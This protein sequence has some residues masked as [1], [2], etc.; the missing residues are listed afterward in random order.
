[1]EKDFVNVQLSPFGVERAA[2]TTMQVHEGQHSF[3]F[4]AGE[5]QR[6]TRAFDWNRVLKHQ[7]FNGH[8]LFEIV[9][10]EEAQDVARLQGLGV[11]ATAGE[12]E[13]VV[14]VPKVE[15]GA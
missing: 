3:F 13:I 10:D 1:M 5:I 8:A 15:V 12:N 6:V 11:D 14:K 7:H 2:G 4:K 9:P